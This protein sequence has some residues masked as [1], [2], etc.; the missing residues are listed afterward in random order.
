MGMYEKPREEGYDYFPIF[1]F[2]LSLK[3]L[4][5]YTFQGKGDEAA[6]FW[7]LPSSLKLLG[8]WKVILETSKCV[9]PVGCLSWAS[10]CTIPTQS[11]D[12]I[13]VVTQTTF[14]KVA[15]WKNLASHWLRLYHTY[16]IQVGGVDEDLVESG[17]PMGWFIDYSC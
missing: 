8:L 12:R 7:H 17:K 5:Q 3:H 6:Y 13:L 2:W 15:G 11:R 1:I 14:G 10:L 16:N 9:I 4:Y